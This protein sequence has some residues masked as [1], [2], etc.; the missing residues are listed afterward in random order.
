MAN[1]P[2][3][4]LKAFSKGN[5]CFYQSKTLQLTAV[6]SDG[7]EVSVDSGKLSL[8]QNQ[9]VIFSRRERQADHQLKVAF[10]YPD[11]LLDQRDVGLPVEAN[12]RRIHCYLFD[13]R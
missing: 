11:D 5:T 10:D 8:P 7:D 3:I 2:K 13:Q 9:A 6:T 4:K 1:Y 12:L